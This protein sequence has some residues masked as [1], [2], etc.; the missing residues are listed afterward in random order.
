[1]NRRIV[2]KGAVAAGALAGVGAFG[3]YSVLALPT[4][5]RL[6]SVDVLAAR[7]FEALPDDARAQACVAYDHPLRQYHNRGLVTGGVFVSGLS[8]D[9]DTRRALGRRQRRDE[10]MRRL[11]L[12]AIHV[13]G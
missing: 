7:V 13:A 6:E 1:M 12:V 5:D 3:R 10:P 2:L 9:W 11:Q 8:L 4:S